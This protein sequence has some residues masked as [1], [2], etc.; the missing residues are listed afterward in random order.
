MTRRRYNY[1]PP[2]PRHPLILATAGQPALRVGELPASV[3]LRPWFQEPR[4]QGQEGCCSGFASSALREGLTAV[5]A[6]TQPDP[7][8]PPSYLSPQFL[9][10]LTR[11]RDGTFPL[12]TGASCAGE[13]LT[14]QVNGVCPEL[15]F[16]YFGRAADTIPVAAY[17]DAP[18]NRIA[19]PQRLDTR[20]PLWIK[21]AL[22]GNQPVIFGMPVTESFEETGM[23][24]QVPAPGG[25]V[26]GGHALLAV[27]YD[28]DEGHFIVRNSWSAAWGVAGYCFLPYYFVTTFFEAWT[29]ALPQPQPKTSP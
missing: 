17:A 24:G 12:D 28:D 27:G 18:A 11:I 14:L 7:L 22:A 8:R 5:A 2:H 3:D 19:L 16:P 6:G 26:L 1:H 23:D 4:N 10:N 15:D 9:Y 13:L 20:A 29:A 21:Q 25:Q